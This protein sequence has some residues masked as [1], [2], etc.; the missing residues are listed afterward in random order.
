MP[1]IFQFDKQKTPESIGAITKFSATTMQ[2]APSTIHFASTATSNGIL[3]NA[4]AITCDLTVSGAGGLDTGSETASTQYYIYA[5]ADTT[6]KLVASL[7][8]VAPTGF[9]DYKLLAKIYNN[10]SSDIDQYSVDAYDGTNFVPN[11]GNMFSYSTSWGAAMGTTTLNEGRW[12]RLNNRLYGE[13]SCR[14]GTPTGAVVAISLPVGLTIDSTNVTNVGENNSG[15]WFTVDGVADYNATTR[16]GFVVSDSS[17][18]VTTIFLSYKATSDGNM[19]HAT[20]TQLFAS[21]DGCAVAFSV[22]ILGWSI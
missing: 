13:I 6:L 11:N 12:W 10:A 19:T 2:L 8:A 3:S 16:S 15:Q 7:S 14:C 18:S 5:I 22:P 21:G 9:T 20:G 1:Q 17:T 4:A